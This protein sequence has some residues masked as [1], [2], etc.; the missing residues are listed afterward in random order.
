[1]I[2]AGSG[3]KVLL[4]ALLSSCYVINEFWRREKDKAYLRPLVHA[5]H[6][7]LR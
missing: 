7:G 4:L 5:M 6:I 1:V 2:G 3:R